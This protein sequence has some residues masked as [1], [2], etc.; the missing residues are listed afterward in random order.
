MNKSIVVTGMGC[1]SAAGNNLA[2][3]SAS[4]FTGSSKDCLNIAPITL[5]D[6]SELTTNIAA[7]V[8]KY[9]PA[10]H[11]NKVQLK[12]LDR[13]AQFA[14]LASEEAVI[15][16]GIKFSPNIAARSCVVFGSSIGGQET[17]EQAY[18]QYYTQHKKRPH[19]FTVP[20][21]LPSAAS[22][23]ISMKYGITG[24]SFATSSACASSGH[25]IAMAA[26]MLRT[27]MVDVAIVGGAEACIT[28]G[29]FHTWEGLRV[30][31]N[32]TC[33]PFSGDRS[34]L[35][36]GEGAGCLILETKEHADKRKAV[37]HA[38]LVGVGMSSDAHNIVQPLAQGAQNSM[39][40]ALQDAQIQTEQIN[41]INA[42]GSAT[43]QNDRTETQAIH[44]LFQLHANKLYVSSTKAIHGHV[45]GAGA[46]IESIAT[47]L[48]LK[49]QQ[50]PPTR[51]YREKD[52]QCD[53]N[54]VVN[55]PITT[56][57]EYAMSNSFAFGGQ[58]CSLIYKK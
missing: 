5:F 16:A 32:D 12:Q 21:L 7:E 26:L 18:Q 17:I 45:L 4:L 19:P 8:K 22:S 2:Q 29:N 58:N 57:I 53:L 54:F 3:F 39:N 13:Y 23:Q 31:S 43:I 10:E 56:N 35:V 14:L 6:P 52:S 46:V 44:Q 15:H 50:V 1:I 33:R 47:I 36:I 48:A 42:H 38:E 11:F 55:Y 40:A 49:K 30:L 51:N 41:Y 9:H 25:A 27:G 34:G 24:P 20:K 37:I 28:L